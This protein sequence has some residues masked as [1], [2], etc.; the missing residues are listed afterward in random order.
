MFYAVDQ[1]KTNWK[2]NFNRGLYEQSEALGFYTISTLYQT[3]LKI[4]YADATEQ[5]VTDYN[6]VQVTLKADVADGSKLFRFDINSDGTYAVNELAFT[7]NSDG[8]IS[9]ETDKLGWFAV[10]NTYKPA[11]ASDNALT[12]GLSV[13][14][15]AIAVL[16]V[17]IIFIVIRKKRIV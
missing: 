12:I 9:F 5:N 14:G 4:R 6:T 7:K 13:G 10:A 15:A 8:T 17:G 11:V 16:L 3:S 1:S 2:A